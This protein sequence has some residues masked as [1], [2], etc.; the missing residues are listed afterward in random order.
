[1]IHLSG[2][3]LVLPDRIVTGGTVAIALVTPD[4]SLDEPLSV[5]WD[6]GRAAQNMVLVAWARVGW[7]SVR[8]I[9]GVNTHEDISA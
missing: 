9:P 5:M 8:R 3:D 6:L 2:A 4:P 7:G 1:M